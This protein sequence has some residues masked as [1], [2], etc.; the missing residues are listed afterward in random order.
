[1]SLVTELMNDCVLGSSSMVAMGRVN[2]EEGRRLLERRRK[3][4]KERRRD[5]RQTE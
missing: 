5:E 4:R 2:V 1:M 3:R